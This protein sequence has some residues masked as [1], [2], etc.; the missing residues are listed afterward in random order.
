MDCSNSTWK[1]DD[2]VQLLSNKAQNGF[3]KLVQ[4]SHK[5]VINCLLQSI[6]RY[7][8]LFTP[9][10][11]NGINIIHSIESHNEWNAQQCSPPLG[12][13]HIEFLNSFFGWH[14][15]ACALFFE[16]AFDVIQSNATH[17]DFSF[18][19]TNKLSIQSHSNPVNTQYSL[20]FR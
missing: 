19:T 18:C 8:Y 2:D 1:N 20:Y 4:G 16:I 5:L 3:Q 6:D 11:V 15:P 14:C 9:S 17:R 13:V 10:F 7:I 12:N